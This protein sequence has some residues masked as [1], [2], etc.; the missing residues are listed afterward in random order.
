[1]SL[2][3]K[4]T[5]DAVLGPL[6]HSS[7]VSV[8]VRP[9]PEVPWEPL[10]PADNIDEV[11]RNL[12]QIIDWAI[13]EKSTIGYFAVLYKRSTVAIR[14]ALNT[15]LFYDP[16]LLDQFDAV[17]A[18]RYFDALNAY[19]HPDDYDGLTLP[20]EVALVR[21]DLGQST[22][23]QH[24][25][26]GLNAH[27]N[28]DLGLATAEIVPDS[29]E[30]FDHDFQLI[31]ALVATQIRGMLRVTEG[32]S[33]AV[34]WIR[35]AVPNEV[36]FIRRALV[37]FRRSGW[38]FAAY[39]LLNPDKAREKEVNHMAWA[40]ALGA[41]YLDPPRYLGLGPRLIAAIATRE[42]RDIDVHLKALDAKAFDPDPLDKRFLDRQFRRRA[43][44]RKD[45][46]AQPVRGQG[47]PPAQPRP[48]H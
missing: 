2:S 28:F 43:L 33:P 6:S 32:I 25:V 8:R 21:Q 40:A 31:N 16:A 13:R 15:G 41:W 29:M 47:D 39:V 9:T 18:K 17:F 24:M 42:N 14:E 12:D 35:R 7:T 45:G 10:R 38:L 27:I 22:M 3:K 4:A 37:K 48:A 30:A 11:V 23:L 34:R 36:G 1:V 5:A 26:A 19:F 46:T 20:W 44:T